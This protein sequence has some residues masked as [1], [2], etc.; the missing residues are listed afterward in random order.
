[1]RVAKNT[2]IINIRLFVTIIVGLF[3]IRYVL[4][5]LGASDFGLYSVLAGV[6]SMITF[7]SSSMSATTTRYINF[8]MGK[9]DGNIK[10]RK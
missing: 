4:Q 9:K 2:L 6:L 10:D 8:E 5:V 7:I 3:T 1:M